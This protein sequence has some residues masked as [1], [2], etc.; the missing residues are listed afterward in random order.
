MRSTIDAL[1]LDGDVVWNRFNG[2]KDGSLWYYRTLSDIFK[3]TG[4]DILTDEY[5]RAVKLLEKMAMG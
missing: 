4:S 3:E 5:T 1:R 2:G